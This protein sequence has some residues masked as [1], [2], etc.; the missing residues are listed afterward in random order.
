M[1]VKNGTL[2]LDIWM[3]MS[4]ESDAEY[5]LS[6]AEYPAWKSDPKVIQD[7][8]DL[9]LLVHNGSAYL[10]SGPDAVNYFLENA[11]KNVNVVGSP[12]FAEPSFRTKRNRT[13]TL[14]TIPPGQ[15]VNIDYYIT[16]ERYVHGGAVVYSNAVLGDTVTAEIMD[17]DGII[18]EPYR[19]ALCEAWPSVS[20]YIEGEW[21]PEGNGRHEINTYPLSAKISAG[22]YLRLTYT[23]VNSGSDRKM[24]IN[25]YL[26]KKL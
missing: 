23:A 17:L 12:P 9:K 1:K 2:A 22:L 21:V 10:A 20:K 13:S 11:T 24:G 26:T 4:I 16:S 18:P 3:G 25:Y 6:A 5:V 14:A 15:T 7:I 19:P 8:S